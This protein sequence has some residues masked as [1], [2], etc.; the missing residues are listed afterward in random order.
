M[1]A[2]ITSLSQAGLPVWK[3]LADFF[4]LWKLPDAYAMPHL[5]DM[6]APK[7]VEAYKKAKKF[8]CQASECLALYPI[9][10][11]FVQTVPMKQNICLPQCQAFIAM[12]DV[13]DILQNIAIQTVEPAQ[14]VQAV[15]T[16][17]EAFVVAGWKQLMIKK[18]HWLLHYGDHLQKFKM[19]P[20]CWSL[21]RKHKL[22]NK[23]ANPLCNTIKFE[24]SV[25]EELLSHELTTLK[26][27]G[28]FESTTILLKP[29]PCSKKFA[30][31]ISQCFNTAVAPD[32]CLVGAHAK[33][34]SS[35]TCSKRD[36][37]LLQ[38]S[39]V[40]NLWEAAEVWAHFELGGRTYSLVSM[41]QLLSY[42]PERSCTKWQSGDWPL[43]LETHDILCCLTYSKSEDGIV[44]ALI[45]Y[46]FRY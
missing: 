13:L 28:L 29:H 31:F 6:F 10:A 16:A 21:E 3:L 34:S 23:F 24:Q 14:L 42:E 43:I 22:V 27:D 37:V 35:F 1:Y 30:Q 7:R 41:L 26:Q 20:A 2:L 40:S 44:T 4:A 15:E 8:K 5:P 9:M 12:C 32:E 36:V 19:L 39:D 45:P 17:L 38:S 46:Q 33:L 11:M 18:F 25:L